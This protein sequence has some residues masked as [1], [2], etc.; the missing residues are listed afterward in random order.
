VVGVDIDYEMV[1]DKGEMMMVS[2]CGM[3]VAVR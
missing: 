3:A 1:G 2:G